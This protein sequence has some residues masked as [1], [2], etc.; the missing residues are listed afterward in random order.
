MK[1]W[2]PEHPY[3]GR[4]DYAIPAGMGMPRLPVKKA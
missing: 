3:A 2:K 4:V 1:I